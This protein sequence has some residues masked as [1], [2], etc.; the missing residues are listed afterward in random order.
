MMVCLWLVYKAKQAPIMLLATMAC[1][2]YSFAT[3]ECAMASRRTNQ[4]INDLI[5]LIGEENLLKKT[6]EELK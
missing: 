4:R 5:E 3:V 1:M 6:Q 2:A